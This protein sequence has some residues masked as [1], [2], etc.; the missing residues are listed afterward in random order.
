M[1]PLYRDIDDDNVINL[2]EQLIVAAGRLATVSDQA[3]TILSDEFD[4]LVRPSV[5]NVRAIL[6]QCPRPSGIWDGKLHDEDII[7]S[8]FDSPGPSGEITRDGIELKHTITGIARQS[9]TLPTKEQNRQVARAA[10]DIAVRKR[11]ESMKTK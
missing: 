3:A 2:F 5:D 9:Y 10:L 4:T 11:Y 8:Y 6:A 7:E 1:S